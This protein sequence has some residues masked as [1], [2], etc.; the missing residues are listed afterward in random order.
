MPRPTADRNF[1]VALG[2]LSSCTENGH[3]QTSFLRRTQCIAR[4]APVCHNAQ[5][6]KLL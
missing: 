3:L 5:V 6:N 1:Y 4:A 2:E